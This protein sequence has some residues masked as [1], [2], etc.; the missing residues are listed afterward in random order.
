M[1]AL[2]RRD[3]SRSEFEYQYVKSDGGVQV[4]SL[5]EFGVTK[6]RSCD[7]NNG[8]LVIRP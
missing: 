5:F 2:S 8:C 7:P 4:F 6:Q 3:K 1:H